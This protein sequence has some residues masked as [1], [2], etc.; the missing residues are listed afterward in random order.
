MIGVHSSR[1]DFTDF[2]LHSYAFVCL[3]WRT[4][5]RWES[6]SSAPAVVLASQPARRLLVASSLPFQP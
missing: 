4:E 6:P 2:D 5:I 3:S 1:S